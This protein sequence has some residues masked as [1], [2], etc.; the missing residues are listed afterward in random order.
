MRR[1]SGTKGYKSYRG[2]STGKTI[3]TVLLILVLLAA[4]GFLA[5]QRYLVYDNDGSYRF[6][7]PWKSEK[8]TAEMGEQ[9]TESKNEVEI[10]VEEPEKP[11]IF[12]LHAVELNEAA[13]EGGWQEMVSDHG[14]EINAVAVCVK[15]NTGEIL[16]DSAIAEAAECGAVVGSGAAREIIKAINESDY[17]TIARISALHDSLYARAHMA[18]AAVCQL[19]GYVWY[20]TNSTHWLAPEKEAARQYVCKVA[21]ECAELG[22]DELLFDDFAYP[23]SGNMS[24]IKTDERTISQQAALAL[25]AD[26]LR[27]TLK[28][29][30]VKLSATVDADIILAGGEER[31]GI[32]MSELAPKFDRIYAVTTAEQLPEL[33]E[34]MKAFDTELIPILQEACAEK[35]YLLGK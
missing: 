3:L 25:L 4:L 9:T 1:K 32:V 31:T 22:F 26:E 29:T 18:D 17:Y 16:Y 20:D 10:I 27:E 35:N 23:R 19:T 34:A 21:K 12:N 7:F 30:E 15:K 6:A 14:E 24:R 33:R 11:V 8:T 2:S 28:D 5:A 13:L